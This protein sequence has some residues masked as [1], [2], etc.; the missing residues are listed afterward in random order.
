MSVSLVVI[1]GSV[2][3]P[4]RASV[5]VFDRGFLYGDSVFETVRT[6]GGKPFALGEHLERLAHSASLVSIDL[7]V[8][9]DVIAEEVERAVA[10]A[11]NDESYVRIMI[12]RGSGEL[13]LDPGL[14]KN[15]LRV[16]IVAPLHPPT[17]ETYASGVSA[18]TYRTQRASDAT[19]AV[20][21]KIGNYLV[22][23]LAMKKARS[24]GAHEALI[25][26]GRGRVVEGATSNVFVVHQGRLTTPPLDA[27]ILAG[28]TRARILDVCKETGREV[29]FRTLGV[30]QVLAADEVFISSSIRELL[31]VIRIDGQVIADGRPGPVTRDLHAAFRENISKIQS[32]G[33]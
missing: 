26:D 25:V 28:I 13:G 24:E 32:L 14:A 33:S 29:E 2:V 1:D 21:A 31:G 18:V 8:S 11:G 30:K 9:L 19:V 17:P 10:A 27:G 12:T 16:I 7:P 20:G 3:A 22:A 6:Y 15:P 4:E 5:S 23:A